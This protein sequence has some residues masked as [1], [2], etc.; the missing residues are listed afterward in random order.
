[1]D[2]NTIKAKLKDASHGFRGKSRESISNNSSYKKNL[3]VDTVFSLI[4]IAD[5]LV[6]TVERENSYIDKLAEKFTA[7]T[8]GMLSK[9][10]EKNDIDAKKSECAEPS[11][12]ERESH[13]LI[14]K[15]PEANNKSFSN[16]TWSNAV[17]SNISKKLEKIPV[18]K[19]LLNQKGQGCIVLPN[20][21]TCTSA[22]TLLERDFDVNQESKKVKPLLPRLK[23]HNVSSEN[24][25]TKEKF[26]EKILHKNTKI[27]NLC[28]QGNPIAVTYYDTKR[29]YAVLKVTPQVKNVIMKDPKIFVGMESLHV[30]EHY[31]ITQCYN[32]QGFGHVSGSEHC[33]R[34]D[35]TPLCL[36]CGG[37][38][39]SSECNNKKTPSNQKMCFKKHS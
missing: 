35:S 37:E 36:Y 7:K 9:L 29:K 32:C 11:N 25:D 15:N 6:N 24:F 16:E 26:T 38:H 12:S 3:L 17:K 34:K 33:P 28:D 13:V 22:K 8:E 18:K 31:H 14:I 21:D 19:V 2:L 27:K 39:R 10:I 1:M 23:I 30:S 20:K 4:E 5:N